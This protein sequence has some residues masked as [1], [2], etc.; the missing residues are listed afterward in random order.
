MERA[1]EASSELYRSYRREVEG[2]RMARSARSGA[3]TVLDARGITGTPEKIAA[4]IE[5]YAALG[6]TH[7]IAMFGR[8]DRLGATELFAKEVMAR[9]R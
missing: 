8:V 3:A 1:P 7:F 9:F 5:E 6:V 2:E 4:K